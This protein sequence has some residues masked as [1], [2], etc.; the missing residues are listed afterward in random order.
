MLCFL[1]PDQRLADLTTKVCWFQ[2]DFDSP[3][4]LTDSFYVLLCMFP[5]C[6]SLRCHNVHEGDLQLWINCWLSSHIRKTLWGVLRWW[7]RRTL[8]YGQEPRGVFNIT[9]KLINIKRKSPGGRMVSGHISHASFS[10][11][12]FN[13]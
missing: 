12:G 8:I 4:V 10:S 2:S 6:K 1:E 11:T 7:L 3:P 13:A 9:G 5:T